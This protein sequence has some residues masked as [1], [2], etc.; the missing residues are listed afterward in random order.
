MNNRERA[1]VV[2]ADQRLARLLSIEKRGDGRW[3]A[4]EIA[5]LG[6][7]WEAYHERQR[8]SA[9]GG[10]SSS[11]HEHENPGFSEREDQEEGRRF[12]RDVARWLA[13]HRR[14]LLGRDRLV[15]FAAPR[16]LGALRPELDA[17]AG[18]TVLASELTGLGPD[19][20][21]SHPAV[22]EAIAQNA[23]YTQPRRGAG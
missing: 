6:S 21:A 10:R 16:F 1:W 5:S 11:T 13:R 14:D 17:D 9:L 7:L 18:V 23:G 2:V 20:L 15:V 19:E 8:P 4:R 22:H 12:A 3:R